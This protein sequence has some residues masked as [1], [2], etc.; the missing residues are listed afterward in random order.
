MEEIA[1]HLDSGHSIIP[2]ISDH[3]LFY[4]SMRSDFRSTFQALFV[5]KYKPFK[6][7]ADNICAKLTSIL[8][9]PVPKDTEFDLKIKKYFPPDVQ[10]FLL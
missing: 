4:L 1:N 8:S 3:H 7:Q 6:K 10:M 5:R 9:K 2:A